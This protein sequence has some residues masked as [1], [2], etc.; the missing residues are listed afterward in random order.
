MT[1]ASAQWRVEVIETETGAVVRSIP[2]TYERKAE[3]VERGILRNL[4][5]DEF[6]T[7]IIEPGS[8]SGDE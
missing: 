6:H 7:R 2:C 3:G 8:F 4:N 5:T 1:E